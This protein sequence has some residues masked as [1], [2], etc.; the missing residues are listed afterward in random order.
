MQTT[1][2]ESGIHMMR[3]LHKLDKP[4]DVL[5]E[6]EKFEEATGQTLDADALEELLTHPKPYTGLV[7]DYLN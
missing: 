6:K 7:G 1:Q 3:A 5:H 2:P 4:N